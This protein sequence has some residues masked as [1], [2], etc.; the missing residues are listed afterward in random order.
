M[1]PLDGV[2][3][4]AMLLVLL[5]HFRAPDIQHPL[6]GIIGLG[7]CGVQLFFVLSGFLI[8][9]ILLDTRGCSN[10]FT[11]FWMRRMLRIFPLYFLALLVLLVVLPA[12]APL[13]ARA[14]PPAADHVYFWTYLNN[15]IPM[16]EGGQLVHILGHFWS[17]ALEEQ[18]YLLWPLAIWLLPPRSLL[19]ACAVGCVAIFLARTWFYFQVDDLGMIYRNTILRADALLYGAAGAVMLRDP[20]LSARLRRHIGALSTLAWT[21]SA[22]VLAA[23]R[24]THYYRMPVM[25][26]GM[27]AFSISFLTLIVQ[28]VITMGRP[29]R[30]QR[31][32]CHRSLT[33]VGKYSYGMYVWHWPLAY[34]LYHLYKG[35]GLSG[36]TGALLML[37]AGLSLSAAAAWASYTWFEEPVLRLKRHF[38]ARRGLRAGNAQPRAFFT[39][40]VNAGTTSKR[41]PTMP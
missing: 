30:L 26:V 3:G 35:L 39:A 31:F 14:L 21:G 23:A 40:S 10:Y 16:E 2:R 15:W 13:P 27:T 29:T 24:G 7:W 18:F 1:P 36:W 8:T 33:A 22:L 32:L 4:L 9:G 17:L 6:K 41:S 28:S 5:I 25:T 12:V 37:S 20:D 11:S 34:A 38:A 19:H